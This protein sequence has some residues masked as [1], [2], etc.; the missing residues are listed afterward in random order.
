VPDSA[1]LKNPL[2]KDGQI[3]CPICRAP[4]TSEDR[5][6][7][8]PRFAYHAACWRPADC[9]WLW[10]KSIPCAALSSPPYVA[11]PSARLFAA[12]RGT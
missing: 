10:M 2:D 4:I 8:A 12:L 5:T 1:G 3:L 6:L 11:E 9:N 7:Q